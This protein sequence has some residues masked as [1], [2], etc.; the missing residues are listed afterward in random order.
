MKPSLWR[1]PVALA[2]AVTATLGSSARPAAAHDSQDGPDGRSCRPSITALPLSGGMVNG[3]VLAVNGDRAAGFV[4]DVKGF[5]HVAVWTRDDHQWRV[6]DLGDF[7]VTAPGE[8]LSATGIDDQG[9][10]AVGIS[11][12]LFEAWLVTRSGVHQLQDFAGGTNAYVRAING[13]GL[14]VGEALDAEGN[15]FAAEW[16]HWWSKP[17][18]LAPAAGYDGSYAQGVNDRG[19][20]AGGSFSFGTLPNV[21]TRWSVAGAPQ[22]LFSTSDAEA[23]TVN[24]AGEVV[25]RALA[26]PRTALVWNGAGAPT[27]LGLFADAT[28]SRA[29]DVNGRGVVVGF[30]ADNPAGQVPVRHLLYWPGQGPTMSLLPL[31]LQW[32]DGALTHVIGPDGT[33]Y[34]SSVVTHDSL[35]VPT[36]WRCASAQAF[37]PTASGPPP[38]Y[39][40]PPVR[41][42]GRR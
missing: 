41:G 23:M 10:I 32:A 8:P 11:S 27:S 15:D 30:E 16:A 9:N 19:Q 25:G 17:I 2:L 33:V 34:G 4:A 21:A 3:D 18:M 5:Q 36:V 26:D 40:P 7:G 42:L 39:H 24:H 12:D 13:D 37:V 22:T 38:G 31:S 28:S 14:M 29:L 20:I 1:A 6:R 35:P